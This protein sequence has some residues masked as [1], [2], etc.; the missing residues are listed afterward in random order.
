MAR[1][2]L[3][4]GIILAI[5]AFPF[6]LGGLFLVIVPPLIQ[7][8]EGYYSSPEINI[9]KGDGV[10][11]VININIDLEGMAWADPSDFVN[12]KFRARSTG[13]AVFIGVAPA[14]EVESFLAPDNYYVIKELNFDWGPWSDPATYE[15]ERHSQ[16]TT[17]RGSDPTWAVSA[18][19]HDK[20]IKWE[21]KEGN[22]SLV[23]YNVGF[24]E[25]FSVALKTGAKIP[26][27]GAIGV[28]ILI[29]G[30][31][32]T[33]LAIVLIIFDVKAHRTKKTPEWAKKAFPEAVA[34][35]PICANCG[36][37][38][39]E[40]DV[41]CVS[42][43]D[44]LSLSK[45]RF[46]SAAPYDQPHPQSE[47][48]LIATWS[49]RFWAFVID[50]IIVGAVLE[51]FRWSIFFAT[52]KQ[53]YFM[54]FRGPDFF[55]SF[56]PFG[57]VLFIYLFLTEW[58]WGQSIGKMALNL[59]VVSQETGEPPTNDPGL[60]ILNSIG[61]AFLFPIDIII[62]LILKDRWEAESGVNLRQRLFQ[63]MSKLTVVKKRS[64]VKVS[65]KFVSL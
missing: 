43:G 40:G 6:V 57:A 33:T 21:P 7:D 44:R 47:Q 61:K 58:K 16:E 10:G 27:I 46:R 56:A 31:L 48:L 25:G 34:G 51:F 62:G 59:E 50:L 8:T 64:E 12:M 3:I 49:S 9:S 26:L 5:F 29:F 14:A 30:A 17:L 39:V 18:Y 60:V 4:A 13:D 65:S 24:T 54:H 52:N 63:R 15:E 32:L 2:K 23:V 41:F 53:D 42:C 19:G 55:W 11:F 35:K 22:W 45:T 20:T 37:P 38:F 36:S 1:L 28:G